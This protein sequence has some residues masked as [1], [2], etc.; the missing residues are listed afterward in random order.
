M[1]EVASG[2]VVREGGEAQGGGSAIGGE[3]GRS[4]EAWALVVMGQFVEELLV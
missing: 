3:D 4:D 1:V 2:G